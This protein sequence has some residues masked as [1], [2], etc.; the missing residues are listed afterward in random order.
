V[1][2]RIKNGGWLSR[3]LGVEARLGGFLSEAGPVAGAVYIG[4]SERTVGQSYCVFGRAG[5]PSA[6][7]NQNPNQTDRQK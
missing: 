5:A 4:Q 7:R 3:G 6:A 1:S 2:G